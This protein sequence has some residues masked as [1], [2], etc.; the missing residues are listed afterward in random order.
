MRRSFRSTSSAFVILIA[1]AS[2]LGA[3]MVERMALERVTHEASRIV[4]AAVAEVRSGR[5]EAG[6]PVTWV[7]LEVARTLKGPGISRFTIKQYGVAEPLPDGTIARVAG[8][9]RYVAGEEVVLFLRADSRRG[10]TSPVGFGQGAY[11]IGRAGPRAVVRSDL[12]TGGP[13]DL[14][15]FLSKVARLVAGA[16]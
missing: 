10:F 8:L 13:Q 5:D 11:R 7:T 15:E 6:L 16:K 3:T 14:D 12:P 9:P 2:P 4:H 1:T